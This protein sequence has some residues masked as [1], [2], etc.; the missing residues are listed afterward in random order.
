[1]VFHKNAISLAVVPL[2]LP[3]AAYGA[4]RESYKGL[5]VRVVPVY[6]GTNDKSIWRLDLLYGRKLI[7]PRLIT[8]LSGTS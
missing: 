3:Q 5:S 6:D 7:D 4:A 1:M 8:R 2:E